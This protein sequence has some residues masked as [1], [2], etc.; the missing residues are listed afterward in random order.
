MRAKAALLESSLNGMTPS[1]SVHES[2]VRERDKKSDLDD[3]RTIREKIADE[4]L[5]RRNILS[6]EFKEKALQSRQP[7]ICTSKASG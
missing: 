4:G 3:I 6:F 2:L 7:H 1:R 5:R